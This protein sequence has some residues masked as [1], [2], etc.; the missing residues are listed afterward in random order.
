[1][2]IF[3]N[4]NLLYI[5]LEYFQQHKLIINKIN[6]PFYFIIEFDSGCIMSGPNN[7]KLIKKDKKNINQIR[8]K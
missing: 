6:I 2:I 7:T 8:A 4:L 5:I 1:M 3:I